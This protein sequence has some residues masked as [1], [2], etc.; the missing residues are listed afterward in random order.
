MSLIQVLLFYFVVREVVAMHGILSF[1]TSI[2]HFSSKSRAYTV[3][4]FRTSRSFAEL[5]R[6]VTPIVRQGHFEG[7][8]QSMMTKSSKARTGTKR[9]VNDA[10]DP[11]DSVKANKSRGKGRG[12]NT[13]ITTDEKGVVLSDDNDSEVKKKTSTKKAPSHQVLTQRH[14]LPKLWR[15]TSNDSNSYSKFP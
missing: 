8:P 13:E 2:C 15:K 14:E 4:P 6:L 12:K 9:K 5:R 11:V 7:T 1:L 3:V 10:V